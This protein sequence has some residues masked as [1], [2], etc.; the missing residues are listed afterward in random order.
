MITEPISTYHANDAYSHSKLETFRRRPA[1]YFKRFVEK[2]IPAP[3]PTTAFRIGSAAH[4]LVL[5]PATF[6]ERF[7]TKPEGIDRRTKEG[8]TAWSQFEAETVGK[9]IIDADELHA[10]EQMQDAVINHPLATQLFS[11][12]KPELT[13][14]TSSEI[15]LQ[16]RTDWFAGDGCELSSGRPYVVDL[17]TVESLDAD[18]FRNF[19]RSVFQFGY[20]RQAG[21]YLPL[22]TEIL[23]TIVQD[24]FFVAVE[25]VEP[26]GCAVFRLSDD[27]LTLGA[28]ETVADLKRL[29]ACA[30][31][32]NW[33]NI[34]P[35]MQHLG[36]PKWYSAKGG[37]K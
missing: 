24:F 23:G 18:A 8:K 30:R 35:T 1:L 17:K 37:A 31:E 7:V 28:D 5:E 26:F 4:A 36:I 16:C 34:D 33:P 15:R 12:G 2:S 3:E 6:S 22:I 11:A 19:E 13:W 21:F 20:H 27:A 14:R 32:N 25:K 10:V 9:T 29:I